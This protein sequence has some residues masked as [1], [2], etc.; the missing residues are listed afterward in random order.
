[1][2]SFQGFQTSFPDVL[3]TK[4][5]PSIRGLFVDGTALESY[6][7]YKL[8]PIAITGLTL[9]RKWSGISICHRPISVRAWS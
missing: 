6:A 8:C 3:E 2:A 5:D 7:S 1:M 4:F 9:N